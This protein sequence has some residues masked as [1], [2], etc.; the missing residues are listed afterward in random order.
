[1]VN[2]N[3]RG[4]TLCNCNINMDRHI[5]ILFDNFCEA[6]SEYGLSSFGKDSTHFVVCETPLASHCICG[7]LNI[8]GQEY[9]E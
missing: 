1:M 2:F 4:P 9:L 5:K 7:K 8:F 6:W 3:A